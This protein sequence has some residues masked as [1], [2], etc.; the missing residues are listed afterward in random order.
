MHPRAL[1]YSF[2]SNILYASQESPK[3]NFSLKMLSHFIGKKLPCPSPPRPK[4]A[5]ALCRSWPRP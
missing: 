3:Q 1:R 5:R 2:L 4:V